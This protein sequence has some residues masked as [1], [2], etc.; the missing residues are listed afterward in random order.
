MSARSTHKEITRLN[1]ALS[2]IGKGAD[3][4]HREYHA[5]MKKINGDTPL[6]GFAREVRRGADRKIATLAESALEVAGD[7][8]K[9]LID[10]NG[11]VVGADGK[12]VSVEEEAEEA[13]VKAVSVLRE[14]MRSDYNELRKQLDELKLPHTPRQRSS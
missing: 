4:D 8:G 6:R 13:A 14:E 7:E 11:A 9:L 12:T 5:V 2:N 1:A 10:E 3:L